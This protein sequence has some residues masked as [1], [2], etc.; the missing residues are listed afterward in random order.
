MSKVTPLSA[1]SA[2]WMSLI[3]LLAIYAVGCFVFEIFSA[4]A[5]MSSLFVKT[6]APNSL[7]LTVFGIITCIAAIK[8]LRKRA[9]MW[10]L[11]AL[12]VG[13]AY[14]VVHLLSIILILAP[15][16]E[17]DVIADFAIETAW[18]QFYIGPVI[19]MAMFALPLTYNLLMRRAPS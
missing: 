7:L 2:I 18:Q 13:I 16:M 3:G 19:V 5:T 10:V 14:F 8:Q 17:L 1:L 4:D 15:R 9:P 12:G 6:L 11:A